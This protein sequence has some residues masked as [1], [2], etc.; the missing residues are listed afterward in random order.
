MTED[1][2][3]VPAD[4]VPPMRFE[5]GAFHLEPLGPDHN[6]RD[7]VAWT[8]SMEHIRSQPG[9]PD[10]RWPRQMSLAE[11]M[12][13]LQ[14]HAKDFTERRG[15][16]YTVLDSYDD[17]VGCLYIY[18]GKDGVH[19]ARVQSWLRAS[20]AAQEQSFRQVVADWLTSDAWP[21]PRP[22]YEPFLD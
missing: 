17:V 3:F 21:F 7:Y 4:F 16:T 5:V 6:E 14:R 2:A 12:S 9:F 19:D 8:S 15:F 20:E 11:N 18:P 10:G 13:D 22:L 1:R